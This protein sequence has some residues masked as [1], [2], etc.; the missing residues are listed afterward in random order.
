MIGPGEPGPGKALLASTVEQEYGII[1]QSNSETNPAS[2]LGAAGGR[3]LIPGVA[4]AVR[5]QSP[6]LGV[7]GRPCPLD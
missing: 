1:N 7:G 2:I 4:L 6:R 5:S 3:A